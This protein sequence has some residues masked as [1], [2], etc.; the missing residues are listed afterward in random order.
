MSE[1]SPVV[2]SQ[3]TLEETEAGQARLQKHLEQVKKNNDSA[4]AVR[5]R[6]QEWLKR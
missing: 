5:K 4:D 6:I 2:K 1:K 3:N